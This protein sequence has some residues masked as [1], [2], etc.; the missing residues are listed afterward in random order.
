[1]ANLSVQRLHCLYIGSI[2]H[3]STLYAFEKHY[4]KKLMAMAENEAFTPNEQ[5]PIMLHLQSIVLFI[6]W[7]VVKKIL[8]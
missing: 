4:D 8:K 3:Q 6:R 7:F 5:V 2:G 1:M